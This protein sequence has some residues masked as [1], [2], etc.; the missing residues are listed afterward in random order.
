MLRY[1]IVLI[2][3]QFLVSSVALA[4]VAVSDGGVS[5][6]EEELQKIVA[7]WTPEMRKAAAADE[8]ERLELINS[9]LVARKM[10]AEIDAL[11]PEEDGDEYWRYQGKLLS[12]KSK[13]RVERFLKTLEYPDMEDLAK[14]RYETEKD[15]YAKVPEKRLSSHIFFKCIAGSPDCDR[16]PFREKAAELLEEL[17]NGADFEAMVQEYSEDPGSKTKKGLFNR[18]LEISQVGVEPNYSGGVFSIDEVDSYSDVVETRFGVHII[19][20]DDIE[21]SHYLPY[22]E[23]REKIIAD[24]EKEYRQLSLKEF[25]SKYLI[26]DDA[27]INGNVVDKLLTPHKPK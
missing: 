3:S 20:L 17:R 22:E 10:A 2:F 16:A 27:Y 12:F 14:E 9:A 21:P 6:S 13:Y 19:R 5:I 7:N 8:G 24:L 23:V 15:K 11:T 4:E 1:L 25:Q 18:W 26:S